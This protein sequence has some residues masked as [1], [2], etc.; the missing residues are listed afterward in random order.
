[1]LRQH[2]FALDARI[3]VQWLG[4]ASSGELRRPHHVDQE[5]IERRIARGHYRYSDNA[6][7]VRTLRRRLPA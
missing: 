2:R 3:I 6:A 7:T 4:P 5:C 1:M